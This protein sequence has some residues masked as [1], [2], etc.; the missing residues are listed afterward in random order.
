[1]TAVALVFAQT[2]GALGAGD[3]ALAVLTAGAVLLVA[4]IGIGIARVITWRR[5]K[6]EAPHRFV[7][8]YRPLSLVAP[9]QPRDE[10]R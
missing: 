4:A 7:Q 8:R 6:R 10:Q 5:R 9:S 2:E 1:M 3:M